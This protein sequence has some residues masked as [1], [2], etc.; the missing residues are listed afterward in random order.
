M[1]FCVYVC[2]LNDVVS[3]WCGTACVLQG[4]SLLGL[5]AVCMYDEGTTICDLI[6]R[7]DPD[8]YESSLTYILL[9]VS[10]PD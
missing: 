3:L 5:Y 1:V 4:G 2:L 10:F 9:Y 7:L 8:S 6:Y